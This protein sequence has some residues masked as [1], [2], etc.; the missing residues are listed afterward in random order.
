VRDAPALPFGSVVEPFGSPGFLI[1]PVSLVV[2]TIIHGNTLF[3]YASLYNSGAFNAV[4]P[5]NRNPKRFLS[6]ILSAINSEEPTNR[7]DLIYFLVS[8]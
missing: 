4:E 3:I 7:P 1:F 6:A 8:T 2:Q 5:K